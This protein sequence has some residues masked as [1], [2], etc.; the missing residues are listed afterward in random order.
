MRL[1]SALW[2][3]AVAPVDSVWRTAFTD[4]INSGACR[5]DAIR[6]AYDALHAEFGTYSLRTFFEGVAKWSQDAILLYDLANAHV[7]LTNSFTESWKDSFL[8]S[9]GAG[10]QAGMQQLRNGMEALPLAFMHPKDSVQLATDIRYGAQVRA[11]QRLAN[12][13][14]GRR[15][16][17]TYEATSGG[18]RSVDADYVVFAVPFTVLNLLRIDPYFSV[19]KRTAIHPAL[20]RSHKGLAPIQ[21]TLVGGVPDS[22][23]RGQGRR[24]NH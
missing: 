10:I 8:S 12:G 5:L 18:E 15:V 16:R 4:G 17:V 9:Q 2:A 3:E 24:C 1:P 6:D 23:R 11:V 7:V 21:D 22:T 19:A 20:C 13:D 14:V